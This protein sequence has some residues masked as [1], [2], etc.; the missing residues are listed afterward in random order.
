MKIRNNRKRSFL[1]WSWSHNN[2]GYTA[3]TKT[4]LP[5]WQCPL[6]GDRPLWLTER[7][8][9][10][11]ARFR[12]EKAN[13]RRPERKWNDRDVADDGEKS[14]KM[15][16][17]ARA[18]TKLASAAMSTGMS[19]IKYIVSSGTIELGYIYFY[20]PCMQLKEAHSVNDFSNF[21]IYSSSLDLL[22]SCQVQVWLLKK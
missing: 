4:Y 3:P 14:L 12:L 18:Y 9:R 21:Q 8:G 5:L 15:Q 11:N 16:K 22:I 7:S 20:R 17:G 13:M 6:L 19:T 10:G 2:L 1:T